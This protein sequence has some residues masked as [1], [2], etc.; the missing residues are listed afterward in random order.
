MADLK[1]LV[2]K[3]APSAYMMVIFMLSLAGIPGTM[4]FVGKWYIFNAAL[5]S[6]QL[7]LGLALAGASII[8]IY[9]YLRVIGI[10]C[11]Q[12]PE[13]EG[14]QTHAFASTG[15]L[16]SLAITVGLSLILGLAPNLIQPL[17][18]AATGLLKP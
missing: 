10:L 13:S 5:Q 7:W 3:D 6:G 17:L 11:F 8:S 18:S 1:G 2:H 12:E 9:Y 16:F 14:T 4:G 15:V